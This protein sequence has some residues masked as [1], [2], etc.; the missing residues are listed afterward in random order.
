[1]NNKL[2]IGELAERAGVA[3]SAIR[4]YEDIGL[5]PA[6]QRGENGYR[7]Y[8]AT[9]AERIRFIQR[10]KA[11]DFSLSEITEIIDLRERGEAPC[12]FVISQINSKL[13]EVERKIAEL[14]KLQNELME[15]QTEIARLPAAQVAAKECVCHI[16]KQES[17][18]HLSE[19]TSG[20]N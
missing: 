5:I 9:D 20:I 7:L 11:L 1:M 3:A 18:V 10:A 12:A 17:L 4:Y 8:R 16:I 2:R 15:L 13:T 14:V 6:A 19:L